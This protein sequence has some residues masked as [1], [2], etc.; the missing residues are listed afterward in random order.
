M[1]QAPL[2]L[3]RTKISR[4]SIV[5]IR[6]N[7]EELSEKALTSGVVFKM[8]DE[9]LVICLD[10]VPNEGL[11]RPLQLELLANEVCLEMHSSEA[12]SVLDNLC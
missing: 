10:T 3:G 5:D 7:R 2:K 6:R 9:Q 11:D 12:N 4:N 1:S 8:T